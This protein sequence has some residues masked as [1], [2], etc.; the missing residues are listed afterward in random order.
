LLASNIIQEES[1]K[2]PLFD[3][4]S[5]L[6]ARPPLES[7]RLFASQSTTANVQQLQQQQHQPQQT[8]F[9]RIDTAEF[10]PFHFRRSDSLMSCEEAPLP[11]LQRMDSFG[12][13]GFQRIDNLA[14]QRQDS[15]ISN[16]EESPRKI[17]RLT[18]IVKSDKNFNINENMGSLIFETPP[19]V[20]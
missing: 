13:I 18:S 19:Q 20:R 2:A 3:I 7:S 8:A 15:V 16:K 14:L 6:V 17:V 4:K 12:G 1:L 10:Q 11:P 9:R 5:I